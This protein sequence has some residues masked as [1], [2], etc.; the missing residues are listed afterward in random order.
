[1]SEEA[2]YREFATLLAKQFEL[3]R[4]VDRYSGEKKLELLNELVQV[5]SQLYK[6]RERPEF[7]RRYMAEHDRLG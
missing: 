3:L 2:D 5:E 7:L 1:M 4:M 6:Y